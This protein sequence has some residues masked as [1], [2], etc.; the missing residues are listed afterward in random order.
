MFPAERSA[1]G[2]AGK[3]GFQSFFDQPFHHHD[4]DSL[5]SQRGRR[6]AG[7]GGQH[8]SAIVQGLGQL[9]P[10]LFSASRAGVSRVSIN[11]KPV[12]AGR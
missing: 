5:A 1:D 6:L 12:F 10:T 2:P 11:S 4:S 9:L 7:T 3:H 8:G